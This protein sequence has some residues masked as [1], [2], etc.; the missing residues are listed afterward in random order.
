MKT[1]FKNI[2]TLIVLFL[3]LFLTGC[4]DLK[5]PE[6]NLEF[7]IGENVDDIDFSKYLQKYGMFGGDEYYGSG[8]FPIIDE[9]NEQRDPD[10]FVLYT[11]TA[12]PDYS[13]SHLHVT[14]ITI[15]DP[16]IYFYDL[17]LTSTKEEISNKMESLG[18]SLERM[19][20]VLIARKGKY[21]FRFSENEIYIRVK[22]TNKLG[23]VF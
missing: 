21:T 23:I 16:E 19:N 11:V 8:Y 13:S 20:D 22:V 5:K 10:V 17:S 4:T 14:S 15:T 9:N 1:F 12:F 2:L 6:T 3:L 18:F 7:W